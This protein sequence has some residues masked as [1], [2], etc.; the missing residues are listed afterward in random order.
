MPHLAIPFSVKI[1]IQRIKA[2]TPKSILARKLESNE[3][4][5][6]EQSI[7]KLD[8]DICNLSPFKDII[9]KPNVIVP[10]ALEEIDIGSVTLIRAAAKNH[11]RVTILSDPRDYPAFLKGLEQGE[12]NEASRASST[13]RVPYLRLPNILGSHIHNLWFKIV[14]GTKKR[15]H[16]FPHIRELPTA[17]EPEA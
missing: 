10:D 11:A 3:R 13:P 8:Y 2:A 9:A 12:I 6:A 16:G 17:V 14:L 1:S 4:N 5:L 15:R 7:D